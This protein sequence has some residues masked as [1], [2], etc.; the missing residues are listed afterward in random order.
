MLGLIGGTGLGSL[1][2]LEGAPVSRSNTSFG[3]AS[4]QSG[5]VADCPLVFLPRHG[6]PARIPPH[7]IN[8]RANIQALAD[9]RVTRIISVNAVGSVDPDLVPGEL[10]IA[11]QLIDY[12]WGRAHT[13]HDDEI[14]HLEFTSPF[15]EDLRHSLMVSAR[16]VSEAQSVPLRTQGVYGCTQGPRLETAAEIQ[17]MARD[18]CDIVGMTL[19]PEA[20]LAAEKGMA[21]AALCMVINKGAGLD[22][23][24]IDMDVM[25]QTLDEV[26]HH[27]RAVVRHFIENRL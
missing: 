10:V 20:A 15:D 17:R 13:F 1:P 21:Y 6:I 3:E 14:R 19:M 5:Q 18:G 16:H 4:W 12:T 25:A 9:Q 27:V 22:G 23:N 8:Y 7:A 2:E 24:A 26:V 11:H